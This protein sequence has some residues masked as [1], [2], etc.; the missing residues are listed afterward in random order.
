MLCLQDLQ[1]VAVTVLPLL[2]GLYDRFY[3]AFAHMGEPNIPIDRPFMATPE[4]LSLLQRLR[5]WSS[6]HHRDHWCVSA[7]RH[8]HDAV[9]ILQG[10]RAVARLHTLGTPHPGL[11][12]CRC[13]PAREVR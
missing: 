12:C 8:G 2:R 1:A 3:E 5:E 4:F 11:R 10:L 6:Q 13:V 9:M 7:C